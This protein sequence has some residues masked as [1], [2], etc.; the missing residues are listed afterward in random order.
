MRR[1]SS[2]PLDRGRWRQSLQSQ[3][4]SPGAAVPATGFGSLMASALRDARAV[5]VHGGLTASLDSGSCC[6]VVQ[7]LAAAACL[8]ARSDL[9]ERACKR[10]DDARAIGFAY[11]LACDRLT[12]TTKRA[13]TSTSH[14]D[15]PASLLRTVSAQSVVRAS[16]TSRAEL[17][18][19]IA[20]QG[21]VAPC[22]PV[23]NWD[24]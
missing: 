13:F 4:S 9:S 21:A 24:G 7:G 2:V 18:R 20:Q 19:R 17:S 1:R 23:A 16:R 3:A 10:S 12:K 22:A 11:L 8:P 15:S 6:S 5:C 14:H